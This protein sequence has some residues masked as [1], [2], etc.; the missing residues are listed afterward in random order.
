MRIKDLFLHIISVLLLAVCFESYGQTEVIP[1]APDY[2]NPEMWITKDADPEGT[3]AD[4]FYVVS[5]WE[6]D[7]TDDQGRTVHYADV[8]KEQHRKHMGIEMKKAC[9]YMSP[10]NR[11]YAPFYRHATIEAFLPQDEDIISERTRISMQDVCDAFDWFVRQRDSSRPLIIV[12]FSQGG[13]AVVNLLKHMDDDTYS[14]LAGAYVMGYKVTEEDMK[15]TDHIKAA[16]G[17]D[18]IGVTICYNTVKDVKYVIPV[19]ANTC[20]AINPVNWVTDD[21]PATLRDSIT[22]TLSPQYHV[23]VV[24][25]Y[26]GS[27]YKAFANFINVGDIHSCEPWLYSECIK[28]NFDLR[29]RMWRQEAARQARSL[30]LLIG[31]YTENT[32]AEGVY[33]YSFDPE[34]ADAELLDMALSGNP[35]FVIP[36]ADGTR[37][38]AVNE[39]HDGREGVS[40]FAL[41]RNT[42]SSLGSV[43]I[44]RYEADGADPCNILYCGKSVL[45]SNYSGGSITAFAIDDNGN[46][47]EMTQYFN[48]GARYYNALTGIPLGEEQ[49]HM[50]CAVVSPDGKYIFVT[51][52]GMDC[53]HRFNYSE[54]I[55]P[56][57]NSTIAWRHQGLTKFGPRHLT[58]SPDGR[59]AYLLCE[60]ADKLVVFSYDNGELR[61]IQTLTAYRVRGHGS[62]DIHLCSDGRHLYTSHRLKE[63]GIAIFNVDT[64]SGKVRRAGYQT[65]GR[66]PRNFAISPDGRYLL[67]ACR[68]DN[69]IEIYSIDAESGSLTRT[70]KVIEVSAPVCVQFI[71]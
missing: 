8:W 41:T 29:A 30:R 70:G 48:I 40:S 2:S 54:S 45:T 4:I 22:V 21:T 64:T 12:G 20:F 57:G 26:E 68:D 11:F 38:Y 24:K 19:I 27:E 39:F 69:R 49:S 36:S 28:E 46:A 7:W 42:I 51:D 14:Q 43:T 34:S 25:G 18:D 3:G 59:F 37:A 65:T 47:T 6:V 33:L 61:P 23:L 58:F 71:P 53:I 60:L 10:G 67:C 13:L 1:E 9:G 35:S 17:A 55:H 56:F 31:T 62:A 66:H 52:L 63:D 50:H 44:P 15:A 32:T 16:Q 5:T